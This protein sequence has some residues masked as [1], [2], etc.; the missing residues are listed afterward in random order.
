MARYLKP[1]F[2]RWPANIVPTLFGDDVFQEWTKRCE[3]VDLKLGAVLGRPLYVCTRKLPGGQICGSMA[4]MS[5]FVEQ[6][7]THKEFLC[8]NCAGERDPGEHQALPMLRVVRLYAQVLVENRCLAMRSAPMRILI[9]APKDDQVW[10]IGHKAPEQLLH[11]TP[12]CPD[13]TLYIEN[14]GSFS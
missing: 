13:K 11:T 7:Q 14:E 5:P 9:H 10:G 3:R 12:A 1:T 2:L 4:A 8:K 6:R